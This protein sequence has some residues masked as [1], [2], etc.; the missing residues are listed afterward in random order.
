MAKKPKVTADGHPRYFDDQFDDEE[1]LYVFHK[2]PIVMRKGLIWSSFGLLAGPLYTLIMTYVHPENPPSMMFFYLSFVVSLLLSTLLMF[3]SWMSW[4][5][6]VFILTNQRFIQITQNG[7][8]HRTVADVPLKLVQSINYEIKG[9][10]QTVLG[11]GTIIMQTFIGDT[12]L[13][14]IHHPAKVQRKIV[15]HMREIGITPEA[16]VNRRVLDDEND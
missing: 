15:E 16:N 6:S 11:F 5:F 7:F 13:H 12:R 2:H 3:P 9:L 4:H 1:V 10:E 14:H 8:F